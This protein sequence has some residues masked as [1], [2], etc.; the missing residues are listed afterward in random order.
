METRGRYNQGIILATKCGGL[1]TILGDL[2]TIWML[3][4]ITRKMYSTKINDVNRFFEKELEVVELLEASKLK[5]ELVIQKV[6][7]ILLFP[8]QSKEVFK[9]DPCKGMHELCL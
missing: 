8:S 2:A 5:L 1:A 3:H 9:I 4:E 7:E 6:S